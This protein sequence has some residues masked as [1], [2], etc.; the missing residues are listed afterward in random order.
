[1][2]LFQ[3]VLLHS[4]LSSNLVVWNNHFI[5]L[6]ASVSQKI[7]WGTKGMD[8]LFHVVLSFNWKNPKAGVIQC[9]VAGIIGTLIHSFE[10][11]WQTWRLDYWPMHLL[12]VS[13]CSLSSLYSTVDWGC[14]YMHSQKPGRMCIAFYYSSTE[15]IQHHFLHTLS[16]EAVK[17]SPE[18]GDGK[19][20]SPS[21]WGRGEVMCW[22]SAWDWW[23]TCCQLRKIQSA[24]SFPSHLEWNP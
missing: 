10:L 6:K 14:L 16:I 22:K 18:S 9:L 4:K 15:I 24:F 19:L 8:C 23:Y 12:I 13:P 20:H 2:A 3:L 1:M 7:R 21:W 11:V 5:M 17:G